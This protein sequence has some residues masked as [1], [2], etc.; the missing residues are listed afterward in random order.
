[1]NSFRVKLPAHVLVL[2][3]LGS[4][5]RKI[6]AT[7]VPCKVDAYMTCGW[8]YIQ[9]E[10]DGKSLFGSGIFEL[11]GFPEDGLCTSECLAVINSE[12]CAEDKSMLLEACTALQC[13]VN[14][15]AACGISSDGNVT[16][17]D[18]CSKG[19]S[20]AIHSSTCEGV[21]EIAPNFK[22]YQD[23]F[24]PSGSECATMACKELLQESCDYFAEEAMGMPAR[25]MCNQTCYDAVK[26]D[27][28]LLPN[29]EM[30]TVEGPNSTMANLTYQ[31]QREFV[32]NSAYGPGAPLCDKPPPEDPYD[33]VDYIP[34][35]TPAP[36]PAPVNCSRAS[37]FDLCIVFEGQLPTFPTTV[38]FTASL[39]FDEPPPGF[40][41]SYQQWRRRLT[42]ETGLPAEVVE[43]AIARTSGTREYGPRL[44][45]APQEWGTE[46]K[47]IIANFANS[48]NNSSDSAPV[49]D[50]KEDIKLG[51][52][53]QTFFVD[54]D[55]ELRSAVTI[56]IETMVEF[57]DPDHAAWF[58]SNIRDALSELFDTWGVLYSTSGTGRLSD[59]LTLV[60]PKDKVVNLRGEGTET[61][62]DGNN[63]KLFPVFVTITLSVLLATAV[64]SSAALAVYF[65]RQ[66]KAGGRGVDDSALLEEGGI[67]K[68]GLL[69]P[70]S[71]VSSIDSRSKGPLEP[72][73]P[74]EQGL[75]VLASPPTQFADGSNVQAMV[76]L[77][78]TDTDEEFVDASSNYR[79]SSSGSSSRAIVELHQ[80]S[81]DGDSEANSPRTSFA[82]SDDSEALPISPPGSQGPASPQSND[83]ST[84]CFQP[85]TYPL[86]PQEEPVPPRTRTYSQTQPIGRA[87]STYRRFE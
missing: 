84:G 6:E 28:C 80:D 71:P 45:E 63:G 17:Q 12:K 26:S 83:G 64:I 5:C 42:Q 70:G 9:P 13:S 14:V 85:E 47:S 68:E 77:D 32:N 1:M 55:N 20:D 48:Y 43:E 37:P 51:N 27:T 73:E 16:W 8:V 7:E 25:S 59:P 50:A 56:D 62:S 22:A 54:P 74:A 67:S 86:R 18:A 40:P 69:Q 79:A 3:L 65:W 72:A 34:I 36:T 75:A 29:I 19:C 38:V 30:L 24:G 2:V 35:R 15:K 41:D 78:L 58:S 4:L 81:E 82:T 87:P 49:V 11:S 66:R 39:T 33:F 23:S 46:Y 53:S 31:N 21:E 57:D 44:V 60:G 52:V 76:A 10:D 61:Y